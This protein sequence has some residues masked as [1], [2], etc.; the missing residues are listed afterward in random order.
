M[1]FL[2]LRRVG[3][4]LCKFGYKK[5]NTV[6]TGK[7][8]GSNIGI[9]F[10]QKTRLKSQVKSSNI[11][12]ASAKIKILCFPVSCPLAYYFRHEEDGF[13]KV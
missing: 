2:G 6:S 13:R 11:E 3:I 9:K 5:R 12:V 8:G 1:S 4:F 7:S 10:D